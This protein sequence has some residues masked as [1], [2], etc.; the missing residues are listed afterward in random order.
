MN[1]SNNRF[2]VQNGKR[3]YCKMDKFSRKVE[4]IV[5]RLAKLV[6]INCAHYE[7]TNYEGFNYYLSE[8]LS[9]LGD[10]VTGFDIG[11]ELE[12]IYLYNIWDFFECYYPK[13]SVKLMQQYIRAYLF[14]FFVLN[15]D[16]H[17]GNW[18][19]LM[20]D[21]LDRNLYIFDNELSF[22]N[23]SHHYITCEFYEGKPEYHHEL[24]ASAIQENMKNLSL[25]I[26][27]SD[28][29]SVQE[30]VKMYE[31]LTPEV[32]NSVLNDVEKH[33]GLKSSRRLEYYDLYVKNYEAIGTVL[34]KYNLVDCLVLK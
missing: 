20:D 2:I 5:E 30:I 12:E 3:Y 14:G 10:F 15:S 13:F 9:S 1:P 28:E 4:L 16:F 29:D 34:K 33:Y 6:D 23:T 26:E 27:V 18:D 17:C 24:K 25:F 8:D 21:N 11:L 31:I 22:D 19:I 7:Y 32:F